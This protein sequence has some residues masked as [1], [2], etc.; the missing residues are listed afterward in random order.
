VHRL[1]PS[2]IQQHMPCETTF[3]SSPCVPLPLTEISFL[4][5]VSFKRA[6]DFFSYSCSLFDSSSSIPSQAAGM[7]KVE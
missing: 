5:L 2:S 6:H 3:L 7:A 1:V 4:V